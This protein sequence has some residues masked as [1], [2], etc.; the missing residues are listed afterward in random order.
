MVAIPHLSMQYK[1]PPYARTILSQR[2]TGRHGISG[3][4]SICLHWRIRENWGGRI[5]IPD[6]FNAAE[7]DW[8]PLVVALDCQILHAPFDD[9]RAEQMAELVAPFCAGL[10]LIEAAPDGTER[11]HRVL[12]SAVRGCDAR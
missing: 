7:V 9:A 1:L 10:H 3:L 6:T 8:S 12:R 5:V 4:L 11:N 2:R